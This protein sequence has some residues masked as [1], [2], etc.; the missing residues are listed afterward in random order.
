LRPFQNFGAGAFTSNLALR[1][2]KIGRDPKNFSKPNR[3]STK[4]LF[5]RLEL[6]R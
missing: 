1:T 5:K 6:F 2:G 4:A 3:A